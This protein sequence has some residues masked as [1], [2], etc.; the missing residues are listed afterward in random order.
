MKMKFKHVS[1]VIIVFFGFLF[2]AY[3]YGHRSPQGFQINAENK[4]MM[5]MPI[6]YKCYSPQMEEAINL[7]VANVTIPQYAFDYVCNKACSLLNSQYFFNFTSR[8]EVPED[9]LSQFPNSTHVCECAAKANVN[10]ILCRKDIGN[11][12]D[13][14]P[15]IL[16][17]QQFGGH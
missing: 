8:I 3:L 5:T 6:F 16:V 10:S 11:K 9:V 15:L 17:V 2:T 7:L 13:W 1:V 4:Q 12:V 14:S